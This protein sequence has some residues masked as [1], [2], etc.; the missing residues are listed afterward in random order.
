MYLPFH[1]GIYEKPKKIETM[2]SGGLQTVF[3]FRHS[4][5]FP[6]TSSDQFGVPIIFFPF[7]NNTI[8]IPISWNSHGTYGNP[9]MGILYSHSR[10]RPITSSRTA[11]VSPKF[12][13]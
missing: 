11:V 3:D 2:S 9:E 6:L 13:L 5:L 8:S 4:L 1:N 10:S 12:S 7:S